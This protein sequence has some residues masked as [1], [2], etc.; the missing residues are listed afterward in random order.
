[1]GR[2]PT[3]PRIRAPE[4]EE[5]WWQKQTIPTRTCDHWCKRRRLTCQ[6]PF[7]TLL[8][9][10]CAS[11]QGIWAGSDQSLLSP[12]MNGSPQALATEPSKSGIWRVELS[13][14]RLLVTSQQF[15]DSLSLR[16]I[17]TF[18]VPVKTNL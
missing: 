8:G 7:G 11:S 12:E 6:S 13:N 10:S 17:P 2:S 5:Q 15:E 3:P 9:S 1:M 4:G 14:S 18:S 16:G